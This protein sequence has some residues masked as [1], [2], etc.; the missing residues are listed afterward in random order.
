MNLKDTF[1]WFSFDLH[2]P[3]LIFFYK[4]SWWFICQC[5]GLRP[6]C[7]FIIISLWC[8]YMVYLRVSSKC[9]TKQQQLNQ[10]SSSTTVTTAYHDIDIQIKKSMYIDIDRSRLKLATVI[11][12][13]DPTHPVLHKRGCRFFYC[14]SWC[15]PLT[16]NV[17]FCPVSWCKWSRH[18]RAVY[19]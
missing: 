15:L 16:W 19:K 7:K 2:D 14:W 10:L 12:L 6:I 11:C 3:L 18:S 13:S 4:Q 8:Y 5:S 9:H 1:I 17:A